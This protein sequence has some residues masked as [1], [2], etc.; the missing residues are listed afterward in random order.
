V[1]GLYF[2]LDYFAN[3]IDTESQPIKILEESGKGK[4]Y[5]ADA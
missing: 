4:F 2:L 3:C 5:N 1:E